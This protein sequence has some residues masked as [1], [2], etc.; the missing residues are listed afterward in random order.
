MDL[1]STPRSRG[2][3]V[4]DLETNGLLAEV[5]KIHCAVIYDIDTE[6][7]RG[8]RPNELGKFFEIYRKATL[9]IG[10][11]II[12]Y[13]IPVIGKLY[14]LS[15]AAD[16][17]LIDTLP[18]ARL[19]YSDIKQEDFPKAKAW[20]KYK[21]GLDAYEAARTASR[22]R[23]E[24]DRQAFLADCPG[25]GF[26]DG[27]WMDPGPYKA[28]R[29]PQEFPG[30][31]VGSHSLEAWGYR[32][33]QEKKGDYS[34]EMKAKGLDPWETFNEDMY[35]YMLQDA[36][37]NV[38]LYRH[39]IDQEGYSA[40]AVALEMACQ[41]LVCRMERNGWPLDVRAA[42]ELYG[43]LTQRRSEL[44]RLLQTAFPPWEIQL[45]D[46]IPK[47][48]NKTKGY[49]AGVPVERFETITFNPSSRDHIADRLTSKYG[50]RPKE[51][52]EGGSP[53]VDDD[54]LKALPFPE[55]LLLAEYFLI[56]KRI[57]QLAE[58][59]QAWLKQVTKK[60]RIHARYNSN[61]ALTGRA[62]HSSPNIAQVPA[63]RAEYGRDCR[64]LFGVPRGWVQLGAD[65]SGLELRCLGSFLTAFD[66]GAYAQVVL[67]GDVH[68]ENAKALY[69]LPLGTERYAPGLDEKGH[70]I[71]IPDHEAKR[72]VAKTFIYAF[73]YGAGPEKLGSIPGVTPEERAAWKASPAHVAALKGIQ[74][75]FARRRMPIPTGTQLCHIYKGEQLTASFLKTFPALKKLLKFVK[76]AAGKGWLK[77]LDG[78]KL[79]IRSEHAALNTL[80]QSAGAVICKSWITD[81]EQSIIASGLKVS[82]GLGEDWDKDADVVFLGWIHDEVQVAVREGLEEQV[83]AILI[84]AGRRAGAP[85]ASWKCPTD[86]EVKAGRNWAECH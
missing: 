74:K 8:F 42:Q 17:E 45:E 35:E 51:Y 68:W 56:Q 50:W 23:W 32:L 47:R 20:K 86:V 75:R 14:G 25:E 80:L 72:D 85:F 77:G 70:P 30:Q 83:S 9:L 84:E 62:T 22:E 81:A 34:K 54:V 38:Q 53:K 40:L 7:L 26:P 48:N 71:P 58:G 13:D 27:P 31:F 18:L 79:P 12:G 61:G 46:F 3:Y 49:L 1:L 63:V 59:N 6:E 29:A 69:G 60:G 11:N 4:F 64:V 36:R 43:V 76:A 28:V 67:H 21:L 52:T 57:G 37:V 41:A 66:S 55:A 33:G 19:I 39:L 2:R 44:D 10:H 78:R 16:C 73:L 15:P 65:Q 5:S 24:E 82:Q